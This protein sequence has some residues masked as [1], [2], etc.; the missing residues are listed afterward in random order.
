MTQILTT[1]AYVTG[2]LA[3]GFLVELPLYNAITATRERYSSVFGK[4]GDSV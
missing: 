4:I 3:L 2:G 1:V